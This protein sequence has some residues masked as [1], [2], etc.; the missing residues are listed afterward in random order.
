MN[1]ADG[2][3]G[4]CPE[5]R[6][7]WCSPRF[8]KTWLFAVSTTQVGQGEEGGFA[9][10]FSAPFIAWFCSQD[11]VLKQYPKQLLPWPEG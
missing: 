9:E 1:R 11:S 6:A 4:G 5:S 2:A 3:Q 8:Y 10:A 7:A